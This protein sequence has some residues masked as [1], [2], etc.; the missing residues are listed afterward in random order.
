[1]IT[2]FIEKNLD[3]VPDYKKEILALI[4]NNQESME[5]LAAVRE[6]QLPDALIAAGF[7]RNKIWDSVFATDTPLADTDVIYFCQHDVSEERDKLLEQRLGKLLPGVCWSVKNQAR[8]HVRNGDRPYISS[9]DAMSFWPEKQTALGIRLEPDGKLHLEHCF[10]LSLQF[11][12]RIDHNEAR[13]VAVFRER[14]QSK[15]WLERWP[16]LIPVENS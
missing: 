7:V 13:S 15:G 10:A 4:S 1:M 9:A 11:N 2:E 5:A 3:A 8:M 14:V 16:E 12:L 6:L